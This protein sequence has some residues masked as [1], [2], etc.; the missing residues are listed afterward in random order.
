M[1]EAFGQAL[2]NFTEPGLWLFLTAGVI[3]GLVIGIIPGFGSLVG[4]A[5]FLPFVFSSAP[6]LFS[7]VLLSPSST[8]WLIARRCN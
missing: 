3:A 7:Y 4:L 1:F 8:S 5:L 2:Q 6:V